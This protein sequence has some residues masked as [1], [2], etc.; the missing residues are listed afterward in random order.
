MTIRTVAA[1][2]AAVVAR[3]GEPDVVRESWPDAGSPPR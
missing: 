1:I 2:A 3:D